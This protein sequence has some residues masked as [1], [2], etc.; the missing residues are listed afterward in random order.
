MAIRNAF[1]RGRAL[2]GG[3]AL[4]GLTSIFVASGCSSAADVNRATSRQRVAVAEKG[5]FGRV[6]PIADGNH[7]N[8][9]YDQSEIDEL[10]RMILEDR[11]P[12][13]L[14]TLYEDVIR[15]AV[16]EPNS[17][18]QYSWINM[19][20]AIAYMIEPSDAK[21]SAIRASL[22]SYR[23]AFSDGLWD[24]YT[25]GGCH[26][27][28]YFVPWFYDLLVAYHPDMLSPD[29]RADLKE[30]FRAS[31]NRLR[32]NSRDQCEVAG[33]GV[34]C[35][36]FV[37]P[38]YDREGK[39]M[40]NF[41][42][43]YSRYMGPSLASALVSG[44]QDAVDYWADSGWPHDLFTFE[45]VTDTF[46]PDSANRYDLTTY[47]LAVYPSGA[48]T[49]SYV[50][51]GFNLEGRT[52]N[53]TTYVP[54]ADGGAYHFAQ[55][56]GA[57]MGAEMAFHNGM[58]GVFTLTDRGTEPALFRTYKRAMQSRDEQDYRADTRTGHPML[59]HDPQIMLGYRR[60]AD[61]LFD[62]T[63]PDVHVDEPCGMEC[64]PEMP[65]PRVWSFFGYPRRVQWTSDGTN[66]PP[67]PPP[68]ATCSG[69]ACDGSA[70]VLRSND[71]T[72]VCGDDFFVWECRDS[73][74][75]LKEPATACSCS[76]R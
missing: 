4:F 13:S 9:Y 11:S 49:D 20:A 74:W 24:W 25:T 32:V 53:T 10:R 60:Y 57:M 12:A 35:A 47:L 14:V 54:G 18:D 19:K 22:F 2:R 34:D 51:E 8:L 61:P 40:S 66:P 17:Y 73:R 37:A 75:A 38:I 15:D 23:E 69:F 5:A 59:W 58:S 42:N 56:S 36:T 45:G 27:C 28:G 76:E 64:G 16:A 44:D 33:P 46:P 68:P 63:V 65:D 39:R 71:G 52:W 6:T 41:P 7:P 62:S 3:L 72:T 29:E 1:A 48:N 43:W 55:M 26:G 67:P 21:A 30:W 70:V 50:R 31:A